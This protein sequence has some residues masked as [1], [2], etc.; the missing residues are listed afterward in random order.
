MKKIFKILAAVIFFPYAIYWLYKVKG[1]KPALAL[2]VAIISISTLM[3]SQNKDSVVD[4]SKTTTNTEKRATSKT[5]SEKSKKG[6]S[7]DVL[8][9]LSSKATYCGMRF[10]EMSDFSRG[11][12]Q[13]AFWE[14]LEQEM[15]TLFLLTT[16]E[17][18]GTSDSFQK[19]VAVSIGIEKNSWKELRTAEDKMDM[20]MEF[21]KKLMN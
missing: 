12:E 16:A 14:R 13:H 20:C 1:W 4:T 6:Y 18:K 17:L 21:Y 9:T 2:F 11:T 5:Q 19:D 8:G 7:A 3:P 10:S 15:N